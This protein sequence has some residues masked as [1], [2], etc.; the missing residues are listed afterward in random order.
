MGAAALGDGLTTLGVN[1]G[2]SSVGGEGLRDVCCWIWANVLACCGREVERGGKEVAT[3]GGE[4]GD[5]DR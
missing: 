5:V 1:G 3:A 4:T 2:E